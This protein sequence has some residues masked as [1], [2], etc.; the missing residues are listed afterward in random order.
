MLLTLSSLDLLEY[1]DGFV[2][3][4]AVI[5]AGVAV[6]ITVTAVDLLPQG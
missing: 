1:L 4:A 3:G 2:P 6:T 5:V